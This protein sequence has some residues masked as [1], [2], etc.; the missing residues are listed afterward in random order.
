MRFLKLNSRA[1]K[2]LPSNL[3]LL[4][5]S[6]K[7]EKSRC[8]GSCFAKFF[9]TRKQ[10]TKIP[11]PCPHP[12]PTKKKKRK[13]VIRAELKSR[14]R[15]RE[16]FC[17]F[18]EL[19]ISRRPTCELASTKQLL[20][21]PGFGLLQVQQLL[22]WEAAEKEA[23]F[24]GRAVFLGLEEEGFFYVKGRMRMSSK[25]LVLWRSW[26][27]AQSKKLTVRETKPET[28]LQEAKCWRPACSGPA[29]KPNTEVF[30]DFLIFCPFLL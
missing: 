22:W 5:I 11:H 3:T 12:S 23:V 19:D 10:K 26:S 20:F 9:S 28:L 24:Q 18:C 4:P 1:G 21:L 14:D 25:A 8:F 30:S 2:K 6:C 13:S 16:D 15:E 29:A 7:K 27:L 17:S